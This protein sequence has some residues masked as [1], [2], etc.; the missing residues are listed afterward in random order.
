[1][2]ILIKTAMAFQNR[3]VSQEELRNSDLP[4]CLKINML[5]RGLCMMPCPDC[6]EPMVALQAYWKDLYCFSSCRFDIDENI[7]NDEQKKRLESIKSMGFEKYRK[8]I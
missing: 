3:F 1:M 7:L 4:Y 5:L 2:S 6:H 8:N